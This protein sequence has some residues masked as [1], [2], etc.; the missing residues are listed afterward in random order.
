MRL[1]IVTEDEG[2]SKVER[3][4]VGGL[5]DGKHGNYFCSVK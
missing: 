2:N 5:K 3:E 4:K 1:Y